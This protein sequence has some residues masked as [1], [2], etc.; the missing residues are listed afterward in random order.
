MAFIETNEIKKLL[1]ELN[2][3]REKVSFEYE[4]II[5]EIAKKVLV[6]FEIAK[7]E[8]ENSYDSFSKKIKKIISKY[9]NILDEAKMI[10]ESISRVYKL[11]IENEAKYLINSHI[12]KEIGITPTILMKIIKKSLAY[13]SKKNVSNEFILW[14][15]RDLNF[16]LKKEEVN[17]LIYRW[18]GKKYLNQDDPYL[19]NVSKKSEIQKVYDYTKGR[20]L[21]LKISLEMTKGGSLKNCN[22]MNGEVEKLQKIHA[23][24]YVKGLQPAPIHFINIEDENMFLYG[25]LNKFFNIKDVFEA[26]KMKLFENMPKKQMLSIF[27]ELLKALAYLHKNN[28]RYGAIIHGDLKPENIFCKWT[29]K[30]EFKAVIGDLDGAKFVNTEL[31]LANP[32]DIQLLPFGTYYTELYFT[33]SDLYSLIECYRRRDQHAWIKCQKKRD[34][35]ALVKTFW[36]MVTGYD[37]IYEQINNAVNVVFPVVNYEIVLEKCGKEVADIFSDTLTKISLKRPS[38]KKLLNIIEL[39]IQRI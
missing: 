39:E 2:F 9:G 10:Y 28:G 30:G 13:L 7:S 29:K 3:H 12:G 26:I 15:W 11:Q 25:S 35:F 36:T 34:I 21:A 31:N 23:N 32:T 16:I 8:F 19:I 6:P 1:E 22:L 5:D 37:L 18:S 24:G 14:N 17:L 38:I 27:K 33:Y 4:K 20:I